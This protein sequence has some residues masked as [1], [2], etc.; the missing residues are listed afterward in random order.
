MECLPSCRPFHA[1]ILLAIGFGKFLRRTGF[2][3]GRRQHIEERITLAHYR[4]GG[5]V[6]ENTLRLIRAEA[7]EATSLA[8]RK[9]MFADISQYFLVGKSPSFTFESLVSW[10]RSTD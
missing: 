4:L 9:A 6:D 7:K 1:E 5:Y 8:A 2:G 3:R 10:V